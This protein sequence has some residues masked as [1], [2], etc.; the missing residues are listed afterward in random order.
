MNLRP[1][2]LVALLFVGATAPLLLPTAAPGAPIDDKRAE[3]ARLQDEIDEHGAKVAALG[4][5]LNA[6]QIRVDEAEEKI[7]DSQRRIDGAQARIG[8][9]TMLIADRAATIYRISGTSGPLESINVED[10]TESGSREKYTDAAAAGD[11]ALVDQLSQAKEDLA[12]Q[13]SDAERTR[14]E[15]GNE[16]DD[17]AGAKAEAATAAAE[18]QGLLDQVNGEIEQYVLEEQARRDAAARAAAA[19]AAP[20]RSSGSAGRSRGGGGPS[21]PPPLGHGGAG[22]AVGYAWAQVGKP[23]CYAGSGPDCYDCSGLTM[24][25]WRA[26]GVSLPHYSGAQAGQ[27]Q[28]IS[29]GQLAPGDLITTSSWSQHV[30]IWVG[31]GYV[32]ATHTGDFIKF[33]AGSG[34]VRAA[35]RISG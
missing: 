4:E 25:A 27:G 1:A 16:R 7:A 19:A 11:E 30:G 8:E 28:A 23:Y 33:V 29:I 35:V 31:G 15:A 32:H 26:G 6:A 17:L 14:E 12:Q 3:A 34:S 5:Q 20:P 2:R 9:L 18:Q 13:K 22:A 24:M 21:G 10:A